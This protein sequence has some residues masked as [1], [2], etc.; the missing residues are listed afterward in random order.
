MNKD[1]QQNCDSDKQ[2]SASSSVKLGGKN[3]QIGGCPPGV[4]EIS[5]GLSKLQVVGQ[6]GKKQQN[7]VQS[8]TAEEPKPVIFLSEKA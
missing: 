8:A 3:Q 2:K 7:W 6:T 1:G 5:S 4:D